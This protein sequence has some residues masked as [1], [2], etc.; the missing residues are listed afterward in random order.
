MKVSVVTLS[1]ICFFCVNLTSLND[2][3]NEVINNLITRQIKWARKEAIIQNTV[4]QPEPTQGIYF[5]T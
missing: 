3:V 1:S 5:L 2:P 4:L